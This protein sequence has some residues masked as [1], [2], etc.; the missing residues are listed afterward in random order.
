MVL[1][2]PCHFPG[3]YL[4]RWSVPFLSVGACID[5]K[6]GRRSRNNASFHLPH[7]TLP[8]T[9]AFF[10]PAAMWVPFHLGCRPGGLHH[11]SGLGTRCV[12]FAV[13]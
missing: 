6:F 13:S 3:L 4:L 10:F 7:T 11:T 8:Q 5:F 1:F 2:S 12:S 9:W